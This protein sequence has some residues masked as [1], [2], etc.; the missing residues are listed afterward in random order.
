V[1]NSKKLLLT[2]AV[3]ALR[4]IEGLAL[5]SYNATVLEKYGADT[6]ARGIAPYFETLLECLITEVWYREDRG[7]R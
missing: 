6:V 3:M 5:V 1:N 4:V 2:N 7:M